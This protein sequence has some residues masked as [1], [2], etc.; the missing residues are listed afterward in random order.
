M[1][2]NAEPKNQTYAEPLRREVCYKQNSC[3]KLRWQFEHGFPG[4]GGLCCEK[5]WK[6]L[7]YF[8]SIWQVLKFRM[9]CSCREKS[10]HT[11]EH[12]FGIFSEISKGLPCFVGTDDGNVIVN[13]ILLFFQTKT[14]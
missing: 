11:I 12:S 4:P 7:I 1:K 14:N 5:Y 10:V 13:E 2:I 8:S 9:D 6:P 3:I